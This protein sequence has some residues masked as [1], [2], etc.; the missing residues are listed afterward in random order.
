MRFILPRIPNTILVAKY[1]TSLSS[2]ALA[3]FLQ[4]VTFVVTARAL[5]PEQLGLFTG[6]TAPIAILTELGG[7]DLRMLLS[8]F[9]Q[10]QIRQRGTPDHIAARRPVLPRAGRSSDRVD[11]AGARMD[12]AIGQ[13]AGS[14]RGGGVVSDLRAR[15]HARR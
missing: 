10:P 1:V 6:L 3:W 13:A 8:Q 7:I 15:D 12:Q 9:V 2:L 11:R 4:L 5:G 14:N